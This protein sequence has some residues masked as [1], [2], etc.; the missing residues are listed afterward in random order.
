M[1]RV[2]NA[3][4]QFKAKD[5]HCLLSQNTMSDPVKKGFCLGSNVSMWTVLPS[6]EIFPQ[7]AVAVITRNG[8]TRISP[9]IPSV[10][11]VQFKQMGDRVF[12]T[13]KS[14]ECVICW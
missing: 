3:G 6:R 13:D 8:L 7:Y 1:C 10:F 5:T 2:P 4:V 11:I 14:G 12:S 9:A